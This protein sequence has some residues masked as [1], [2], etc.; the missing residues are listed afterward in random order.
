MP[1]ARFEFEQWVPFPLEQVFLFFANPN[2]LPKIMPQKTATRIDGMNLKNPVI[3]SEAEGPCVPHPE[4]LAGVGSEIVT[5]F[6]VLP[7]LPIRATWVAL[8]TEFEWNHHFAD[9]QKLGPFHSFHHRHELKAE[10]REGIN[11]TVVTDRIE[12][13]VGYGWI[14]KTIEKLFIKRQMEQMF[15]QRQKALPRLLAT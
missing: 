4:H 6:R 10:V 9:I 3:P 7:Y 5:S 1:P 12:L 2:N 8:I 11:G 15:Q 13:E 14:G